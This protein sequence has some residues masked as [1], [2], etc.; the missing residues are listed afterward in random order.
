MIVNLANP[1]T[2]KT[3]SVNLNDIPY[4]GKKMGDKVD[5]S[6]IG[7]KGSGVITGGSSTD[8]I[9]M[10]PFLEIASQKV[11]LLS[12]GIAFKPR[13]DGE[14]KRKTVHGRI[15]SDKISQLNIKIVDVDS[16]VNLDELFPKKVE[17]KK[18]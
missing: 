16:A 8:G 13:F 15:V 17:E 7:V 10:V 9:P 1:K 12:E 14:K 3:Y 4:V 11:V 2:S 18:K 5:L 6:V